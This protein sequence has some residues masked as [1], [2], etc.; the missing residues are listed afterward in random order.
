MNIEKKLSSLKEYVKSMAASDADSIVKD[1]Q[2]RVEEIKES[3]VVKAENSYNEIIEEAKRHADLL[4]RRE[5]SQTSA[6]CSKMLMDARNEI[7][8]TA[9]D[10]LREKISG[11]TNN[12]AY[13]DFL[14]RTTVEAI[15]ALEEKKVVVK[16]RKKDK[17]TIKK[18][19]DILKKEMKDVDIHLSK[20]DADIIGGV[21][22]ETEDGRVIIE[23]TLENKFEEIKERFSSILFSK[24]KS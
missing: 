17:S 13:A 16:V 5:I 10:E 9:I 19:L 7:L 18:I 1:A 4:I 21:I 2:K 3:Y 24:L 6:K 12:E 20:E 15:K 8:R 11:I 23:N 22:V 14:K